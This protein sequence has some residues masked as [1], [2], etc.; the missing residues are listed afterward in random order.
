MRK[1]TSH[2][3]KI[4]RNRIS[5]EDDLKVNKTIVKEE[6]VTRRQGE[7]ITGILPDRMMTSQKDNLCKRQEESRTGR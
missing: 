3:D 5:L 2:E 6:N 1:K 4:Q 7:A